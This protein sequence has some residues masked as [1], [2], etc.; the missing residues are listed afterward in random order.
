MVVGLP[1]RLT[2]EFDPK[3]NFAPA[4]VNRDHGARVGHN[5]FVADASWQMTVKD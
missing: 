1:D 4:F 5:Q 2:S 3:R